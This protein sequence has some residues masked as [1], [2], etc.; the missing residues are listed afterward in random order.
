MAFRRHVRII[1]REKSR[2]EVPMLHV[3]LYFLITELTTNQPFEG[4]HGIL[5]VHDSLS[6]GRQA[7][8]TFTMFRERDDGG[9]CPC[10][11]GVLDN[12]RSLALHDRDARVGCS[13]VNTDNRTYRLMDILRK[14]NDTY[15]HPRPL[16]SCSLQL[17]NEEGPGGSEYNT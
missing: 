7:D 13:Q 15:T 1:R 9:C 12:T 6:L 10:A 11:F 3:V 5:R 14:S 16:S 17:G 2:R 4:K 8:K